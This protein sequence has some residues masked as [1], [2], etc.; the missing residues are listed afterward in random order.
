MPSFL[1]L[2][3]RPKDDVRA[4][5]GYIRD[6]GKGWA[7]L[8]GLLPEL[9]KQFRAYPKGY[10]QV[11][12]LR[13]TSGQRRH[14]TSLNKLYDSK[15]KRFSYIKETRRSDRLGAC[16]YCGL[17][18]NVSVDHYL[19]RL[20]AGF[21][22]LSVC[23]ANLV[24]ACADCQQSKGSFFSGRPSTSPIR[25]LRMRNL[26][27]P[28]RIL[29]PYFDQFLSRHVVRLV[30]TPDARGS[31]L[32]RAV[33][34][35]LSCSA[36]HRRLV[37]FHLR[38]LKV[39]GR[40]ALPLRRYHRAIVEEIS[41]VKTLAGAESRLA[42]MSRAAIARAGGAIN[43]LEAVYIRSLLSDSAA[44]SRLMHEAVQPA[45]ALRRVGK[46]FNVYT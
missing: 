21:P 7:A 41:G 4:L 46:A 33:E 39:T 24:P 27:D 1:S 43:S 40:A 19:P 15:S 38:T 37:A 32:L 12:L 5:K 18:G 9:E 30:H 34:S 29:H 25:H 2:A 31:P 6:E 42:R 35:S 3:R 10:G 23:S 20:V 14:A 28:L 45:K 16:P 22:N 36:A 17:P 8:H 11:A 26:A 13:P 44:I